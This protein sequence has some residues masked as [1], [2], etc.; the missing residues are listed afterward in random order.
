MDVTIQGMAVT[1]PLSFLTPKKSPIPL[2]IW[3]GERDG[4]AEMASLDG[5]A[6]ANYILGFE[7]W[8]AK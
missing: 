7:Q 6:S 3:G 5:T 2:S 8:E 4:L 1:I